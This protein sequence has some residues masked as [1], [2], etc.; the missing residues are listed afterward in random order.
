MA[1]FIRRFTTD[2]GNDILLNIESVN[3]ID[4]DPPA[5]ITGV[6]TGTAMLVGEFENGPFN[7]ATEITGA[8][9]M[10]Q[11]FGSLGYTYGGTTGQNPSARTR[12]ADSAVAPEYW[13]GNGAVQLSGKRFSRLVLVRVDTS[14]GSVSF[15]RLGSSTGVAKPSY[16]ITTADTLSFKINGAGAVT[17][18][19]TAVAA[20]TT[21]ASATY[22]IVGG[23]TVTLQ[24]DSAPAFTV[25][26]LSTDTTQ[27]AVI[28]RINQYA[29]FTYASTST[30]EVRLTS[31]QKG[32]GAKNV[33][34]GFDTG[35]TAAKLGLTAG[36]VS[37]SGNVAN[38][39]AVTFAELKLIVETALT[40]TTMDQTS[41]GAPRLSS[42]TALTGTVE[43]ST[44]TTATDFGFSAGVG[45]AVTGDAGKIP[46]GTVVKTSGPVKYVT[47]QDVAVTAASAGPYTVKVRHATDDGTGTASIAGSITLVDSVS[48]IDL[49]AFS[50]INLTPTV[51]AL[52]ESQ[53][54]AAYSAAFDATLDI[55]TVA[56]VINVAWSARQSNSVRRKGKDNALSASANGCF[57]RMFLAR[58]PMALAKAIAKGTSEPGVGPYRD[59]RV[60]YC[61]PN[62]RTNVPGIARLG[63][64]GGTG[65][66]VDG[67]V[68]VGADGFLASVLSQLPPEENPGQDAGLLGNIIGIE[69]GL[70]S[71]SLT[72]SDYIAFK[73]A[74]ICA[75]RMDAGTASFQSGVTSIDPLAYPN[76][77][78]IARR[79]MADFIQDTLANRITGFG[80]KLS[81]IRR[82]KALLA[83]VRGFLK[84]LLSPDDLA[85]QRIAAFSA[86]DKQGNTPTTLG[87]GLYRVKVAVT[88]ISSLDSIVLDTT[89]GET[90]D[91]TEAA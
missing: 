27:A 18:T 14:V 45:T 44:P 76:L 6:G 33:V 4:R 5:A 26:F 7:L 59:Q 40:G 16:Q 75:L 73:A 38:S 66:T 47:M 77:K 29:G 63:L 86:S 62:A 28:A 24:Y 87:Q 1:N 12:N 53:I 80:K 19:F 9:D 15:S 52:T 51:A 42:N 91:V 82:R 89:I 56:K 54:D 78:N 88:T 8:E 2:P 68:D 55:N 72:M 74:G 35:A 60:V 22:A 58:S 34:V 83:E 21:G 13:N 36:T 69:S 11:T 39:N 50:V 25:T 20:V 90:V 48:P 67:N 30:T 32:S 46:A 64:S 23:E 41:S 49:A 43:L 85:S 71:Q 81:T 10:Q 79:R 3:V 57:G 37:G 17:A 84:G 65:F 70:S 31:R 61:Y